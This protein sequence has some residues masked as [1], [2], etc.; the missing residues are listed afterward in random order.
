MPLQDLFRRPVTLDLTRPAPTTR[1]LAAPRPPLMHRPNL[2]LGSS[3][4]I[5]STDAARRSIAKTSS[6]RLLLLPRAPRQRRVQRYPPLDHPRGHTGIVTGIG[7]VSSVLM[8][9]GTVVTDTA[10]DGRRSIMPSGLRTSFIK[11]PCLC[12]DRDDCLFYCGTGARHP[13]WRFSRILFPSWLDPL[14]LNMAPGSCRVASVR[15]WYLPLWTLP[16]LRIIHLL[17]PD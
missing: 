12:L 7:T 8:T 3:P 2:Q 9:H 15:L 17:A 10:V 14:V 5:R 1:S 4:K 16:R 13:P 6:M 11:T